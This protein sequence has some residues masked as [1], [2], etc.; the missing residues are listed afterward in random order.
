MKQPSAL[1][2]FADRL[3]LRSNLS[4]EETEAILALKGREV[5]SKARTVIVRPG[6]TI[7]FA[8]LVVQGVVG[9]FDQLLDRTRQITA[10]HIPGDMCDL[11]SVAVPHAG[12]GIEALTASTTIRVP[13]DALR[14]LTADYPALA[15]AF[16]RDTIADASI[17]AKWV[18][19][20]G[21]RK[22]NARL[23]HLICEMGV[24][25]E[26]AHL[27]RRTRFKLP[28]TQTQLADVLG[29]TLTH[30]HSC[31]TALRREEILDLNGYDICVNDLDHLIE[32]AQFD[33]AYLL[34]E[35]RT[36]L[37]RA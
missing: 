22:A 25:M 11:H 34:S 5:R 24:R 27:G 4:R 16:W 20:I 18:S 9:R 15:L 2:R 30:V 33:P 31:L 32:I 12:W 14:K 17:L 7:D 29:L 26:Q 36:R 19:A 21:R 23:A 35:D 3:R 10:L 28:L 1:E 13:H 8:C 6:Q 37:G